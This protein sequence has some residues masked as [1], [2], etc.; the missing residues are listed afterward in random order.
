M[1]LQTYGMI[2]KYMLACMD[3]S[4]H[5]KEHI[6]RV[7]YVALDIAGY[8][9][10]VNYDVLICACLLHDIGRRQQ[11]EN[12]KLCHAIIGSEKAYE[13]LVSKDFEPEYAEKVKECIRAHRFRTDFQPQS[14]E[15]KIL[16][17]A[18]KIDVTGTLG[19]ARTLFYK[20]QASEPLYSLMPNGQV[21]NGQGDVLPSF[22]QEYKF[23]LEGL[24]TRF[25]TNRGAEIAAERQ[26]SAK[27]FYDNML[28]EVE[29]SYRVGQ[30]LLLQHIALPLE[31]Q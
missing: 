26:A 1:D 28:R 3:D 31:Q 18:D 8:E 21:S 24:Y 13:F 30:D 12:S 11:F 22:F 5:D 6:Y 16:F 2:E 7:L 14:I 25:Y 27:A 4:A 17:D 20:G 23:K 9:E 29:S 15:A 19:I 10:D